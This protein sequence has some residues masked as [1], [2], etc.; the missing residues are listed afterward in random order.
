MALSAPFI[1]QHRFTTDRHGFDQDAVRRYLG[2]LAEAVGRGDPPDPEAIARRDF[3]TARRGF[4]KEEVRS[5]LAAV[6]LA[7]LRQHAA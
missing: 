6:A 4:A 1:T 3:P 2:E 7:V 5:H